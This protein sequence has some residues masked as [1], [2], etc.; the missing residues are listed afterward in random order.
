MKFWLRIKNG[1]NLKRRKNLNVILLIKDFT[2]RF[3][4]GMDN[5]IMLLPKLV[6]SK[7]TDILRTVHFRYYYVFYF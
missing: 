1:W 3:K 5:M 7:N 4:V 2:S 6:L